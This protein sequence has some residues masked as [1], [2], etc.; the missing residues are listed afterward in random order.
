LVEIEVGSDNVEM[1]SVLENNLY[2]HVE[3]VAGE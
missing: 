3:N 2:H 1:P